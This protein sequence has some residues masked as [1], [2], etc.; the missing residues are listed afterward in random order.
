MPKT[1]TTN[2]KSRHATLRA[3]PQAVMSK[4][5][6]FPS[7]AYSLVKPY[8]SL[9]AIISLILLMTVGVTAALTATQ[10]VT[11]QVSESA[12]LAVSGFVFGQVNPREEAV[13]TIKNQTT[14]TL[15]AQTS[16]PVSRILVGEGSLVNQGTQI[17]QQ[18]S[19][20]NA[21][22]AA[23]V[24]LDIARKNQEL[25]QVS[26]ESTRTQVEL[27]RTQADLN[28]DNASQLRDISRQSVSET[29][30]MISLIETI[31]AQIEQDIR[32]EQE[33]ANNPVTIQNLR[34]A[35]TGPKASLNQARQQLRSLEY[36]V[37][38]DSPGAQ[39]SGVAHDLAMEA[40]A[41][42]LSTATI[43]AEIAALN[44]RS[45]QIMA[46][47]SRVSSPL[48]GRVERILVRPGQFVNPGTPV[49]IIK[50]EPKLMLEVLVSGRLA[51]QINQ[52]ELAV[53]TLG[54][55]Q[56]SLT[57]SHLSSAPTA[58]N[59]HE[60]LIEVPANYQSQIFENMTVAVL[61]PLFQF[62]PVEG[63]G[64]IPLDSVFVTN[65]ERFVFVVEDGLAR[66]RLV[67]TGQIVGSSIELKTGLVEGDV[68]L[69][70]RRVMDGQRVEVM[71]KPEV[72]TIQELG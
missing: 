25:A 42:Q 13:G 20:Y 62:S 61:L 44:L 7:K 43:Q 68:V 11:D 26:L 50:G 63:H 57:I 15:V 32:T 41:L 21:G 56:V 14:L 65:T 39:L 45:A 17:L 51:G 10:P 54:E 47:A 3:L 52:E 18:D 9:M 59:L 53:I 48:S 23:F 71:V 30:S 22:Q 6:S 33:G 16:G 2:K 58:G 38:E 8:R 49:A 34:Q 55:N 46:A 69:L 19:A 35:L 27:S 70:D 1:R 64:F 24:S 28:K 29:K 67:E 72:T 60:V 4:L 66:K 31:V 37:D 12:P 40:T 36:Q 5:R